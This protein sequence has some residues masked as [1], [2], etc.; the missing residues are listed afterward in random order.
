MEVSGQLRDPASLPQGKSLGRPQ[1]RHGFYGEEKKLASVGIR[2]P[3]AQLVA[4]PTKLSWLYL[5]PGLGIIKQNQ[6]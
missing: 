4:I 1:S 2:I 6:F 3:T 5:V